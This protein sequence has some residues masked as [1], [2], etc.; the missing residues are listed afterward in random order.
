M[1]IGTGW[2][3][4]KDGRANNKG[5]SKKC[6]RN[7]FLVN[8]WKSSIEKTVIP[9]GYFVYSSNCA[10][11]TLLDSNMQSIMNLCP[12]EK[13]LHCHDSQG[14]RVMGAQFALINGCNFLYVEQDCLVYGL[15]KILEFAKDKKIVYGYDEWSWQIGWAEDS[16]LYISKDYLCKYITLSNENKLVDNISTTPEID[17]QRV[18][19]A[20]ADYW[21]FG[22]GRKRPI[23]FT[24]KCFYAQQL[25]DEELDLFLELIR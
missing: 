20:D 1:I 9:A 7:D 12:V 17:F 2:C 24:Q 23:D 6:Y 14:S 11:P 21:P 19:S 22:F 16:L 25:N 18:F 4:H 3:A 15:D 10:M 8:T 5:T 13:Q